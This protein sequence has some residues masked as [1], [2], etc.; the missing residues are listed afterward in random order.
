M[1]TIRIRKSKDDS[2]KV[3]QVVTTLPEFD[4]IDFNQKVMEIL[5]RCQSEIEYRISDSIDYTK[6]VQRVL[7]QDEPSFTNLEKYFMKEN[8]N[9][10]KDILK[11]GIIPLVISKTMYNH[12]LSIVE[13]EYLNKD[14]SIIVTQLKTI[15][16]QMTLTFVRIIFEDI[17]RNVRN[18]SKFYEKSNQVLQDRA[19][20]NWEQVEQQYGNNVVF[21]LLSLL[22]QSIPEVSI[23]IST[24]D[25]SRVIDSSKNMYCIFK[26]SLTFSHDGMKNLYQQMEMLNTEV[27]ITDVYFLDDKET[28]RSEYSLY[29]YLVVDMRSK[30]IDI[31]NCVLLENND[32]NFNLLFHEAT[33]TF[34]NERRHNYIY[35]N[36][37]IYLLSFNIFLK[38]MIK[39]ADRIKYLLAGSTI[40]SAYNVRDCADVDFF[41]LDHEDEIEKYSSYK[42]NVGV[43]GIFDDFGKTYYGNEQFYFPMI[44]EMYEKQRELKERQRAEIEQERKVPSPAVREPLMILN[45]FPKYSVS[46]LK[47]GRYIDIFSGE[48]QRIGYDIWNLDDLVTNPDNR[49]YFLGCPLI[50]LK[51][52]L[53]RDNIKDI[54][55]ERLSRKQLHDLHFL[56]TN[57][58]YLFI[59]SDL[60]EFPFLKRDMRD[61]KIKLTLNSYHKPLV[62]DD[63]IGYDLVIRRYPLYMEDIIQKLILESPLLVSRDNDIDD[64]DARLVY[65][66]PLLS[67]L[68][69]V[70]M[71][72][73]KGKPSIEV[74][75]IYYYEVSVSGELKIYI[76]PAVSQ[77]KE[78][79]LFKDIVLAGNI[80]VEMTDAGKKL[81][82]SVSASKMKKIFSQLVG[83]ERVKE[84]RIMLLN[85]MKNLIN[86]H[87]MV[88]CHT[89][90][91][92]FVETLAKL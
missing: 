85:F 75:V 37:Y 33:I 12:V 82:V 63:K 14:V 40:K 89:K 10:V 69:G 20:Q 78:I 58:A 32:R 41:V 31:E 62:S 57:Y 50:H 49:I 16:F 52:E 55:L 13:N 29:S 71:N 65:Q 18:K 77:T 79:S 68:P 53:V 90:E 19:V 23:Y 88:D 87:K 7:I 26:K 72:I 34:L 59:S 15:N 36:L 44:P 25:M 56:K 76:F 91:R 2:K 43:P 4:T 17:C 48:C 39:P 60:V 9:S 38:T 64:I 92:I 46:G 30:K 47:A 84:Y 11:K 74:P 27:D 83:P 45:N 21:F 22:I 66:K 5:K 51:L 73:M 80:K 86:L 6:S 67:T 61:P 8:L 42:P 35:N 81:M 54:D 24:N 1:K 28:P 3:Q 70:L